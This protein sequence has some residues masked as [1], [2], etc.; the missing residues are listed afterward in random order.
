MFVRSQLQIQHL[1]LPLDESSNI[2]TLYKKHVKVE[3][4][5]QQ[6]QTNLHFIRNPLGIAQSAFWSSRY[7]RDSLLRNGLR[8]LCGRYLKSSFG[9]KS[10][11]SVANSQRTL[12]P[13]PITPIK[14]RNRTIFVKR[15]DLLQVANVAGSKLRKFHSLFVEN[16]IQ[17]YD[18]IVSYGGAQSNA[19]L[20]LAYLC[21]HFGKRFV[22]IT[23]PTPQRISGSR[24]NLRVAVEVGMEH[25]QIGLEAFRDGF[26]DTKPQEI[27]DVAFNILHDLGYNISQKNSLFIPQGGAWPGAEYGVK[28]L[29]YELQDQIKQLRMEGLLALKRP[30]VFLSAGTGTTAFYLQKYLQSHA[31]VVA[32]PVSGDER[33]LVKQIRWLDS[34]DVNAGEN[35]KTT[36]FPDILRPR[37]RA[38]FGD[39]R[40][41]KLAMWKEL[42]RSTGGAFDFD[43]VY[44]PKT[45][46]EVMLAI[47]EKRLAARDE[48]L[49]YYHSG[50]AEGNASMLDRFARAGLK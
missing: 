9:V 28:I 13:T 22:Y 10:L 17:R 49:I 44:A 45:W 46:E 32:V 1:V 29:A 18:C 12:S 25:V 31:K 43:L 15:D 20:A 27:G 35:M 33:Y 40:P 38:T 7:S 5:G 3:F 42:S 39:I 16:A 21:E 14:F 37:L 36:P 30:I 50:G 11:C 23:R 41:E 26:T 2:S 19:M 34:Y 6:K 47:Q 8:Q 48:D 4:F 24:G